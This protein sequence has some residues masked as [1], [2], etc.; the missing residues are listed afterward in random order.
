MIV[1]VDSEHAALFQCLQGEDPSGIARLILT[2]SGGPFRGMNRSQLKRVT[3]EEALRHPRWRMG[4]KI[5]IDSA[6]LMNKGF[7]VLEARWLFDV[8]LD[9][10]E[11]IVHPQSMVH[12][13][14]EFVDGSVKAQ[15]A[16]P[17]MRIPI[18]YA[19]T[20]PARKA[21]SF[22]KVDLVTQSWG[23]ER[24]D[25]EKF[26]ALEYA[27]RAGKIGGTMPACLNAVSYTHLLQPGPSDGGY[28]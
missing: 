17:D 13:L 22:P 23:F 16:P 21:S 1:P 2:A 12:S 6:T 10:I 24:P 28:L 9:Q 15:I 3:P 11:V 14:V 5:T 20:Y 7:E 25:M 18:Q 26:P 8:G 4:P 27:Y 19:L